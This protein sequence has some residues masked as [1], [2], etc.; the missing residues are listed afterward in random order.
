MWLYVLLVRIAALFNAK[1]RK[2]AEGER[3]ALTFLS[4]KIDWNCNYIWFHAASVGEFEQA[5]PVIERLR[6]DLVKSGDVRTKILLTF[7]SPSGYELRKNYEGADLVCYLPFAT[8]RNVRRFLDIV[9]PAKAVFVKYEY[10][11]AYLHELKRRGIS[12]YIISAIFRPSQLFFKWYGVW[13]RKLLDCFTTLFVQDSE[14]DVLLGQYG[15]HNVVVAGDT[16]FD[17]VVQIAQQAKENQ[18]IAAFRP[19]LI[20]GSTWQPDENLLI[21]YF[22]ENGSIRMLVVPHELDK[23]HLDRLR[24]ELGEE[25]VFYTE[26]TEQRVISSRCLVLDTIG[27][28]SSAY[29]YGRVAYIGGG[30]GVGIHNTL[31]AATYS[32]PVVFGPNYHKFREACDL[33]DCGGGFSVGNYEE[34]KNILDR[35]LADSKVAG[36]KAGKYVNSHRGATDIIYNRIFK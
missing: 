30:F 25:A 33:I 12:T 7:F 24:Q 5:R 27:M 11:P 4:E 16:R 9:R 10:W 6:S 28:L 15:I 18:L 34:L 26:A 23:S 14:S 17:R 13:Y 32:M 21:K 3:K 35:L 8:R 36:E 29:R 19:D 31:E 22:H 1:A 20:C 2:L